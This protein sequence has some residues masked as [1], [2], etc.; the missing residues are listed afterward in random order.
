MRYEENH[1]NDQ[2][3]PNVNN[4][5]R[6]KYLKMYP[7]RVFNA[8]TSTS[9]YKPLSVVVLLLLAYYVKD[10]RCKIAIGA[11]AIVILAVIGK[12]MMTPCEVCDKAR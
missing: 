1:P 5:L 12:E 9:V 8:M 3:T 11:L 2:R 4:T 7:N 10:T 6:N